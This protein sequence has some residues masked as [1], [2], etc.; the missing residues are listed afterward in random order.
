MEASVVMFE[1]A[2]SPSEYR[3]LRSLPLQM[4]L[5]YRILG[6]PIAAIVGLALVPYASTTLA[7][8]LTLWISFALCALSLDFVWGRA[9][10]FSFG[11][12]ALFGLGGYAYAVVALNLFPNTQETLTAL[13]ASGVVGALAA[14]ALGYFLFYSRL[15]DVYLSIVTLAVT[16]IIYTVLASTAGPEYHIGDAQLGGFNGIPS[17]PGMAFPDWMHIAD[18]ELSIRQLLAFA[19]VFAAAM[20]FGLSLLV[21]SSFGLQIDGLRSNELRMELLGYDVRRLKIVAFSIGGAVAGFGGGLF[22]AWGTFVNPSVFSLAQA[23]TVVVWVMIGGRGSL[24]GAFVGVFVVQ[25]VAD[26]ADLVVKQQTPLL[27]GAMLIFVVTLMPQGIV[28][29]VRKAFRFANLEDSLPLI[30]NVHATKAAAARTSRGEVSVRSIAKSFD[31]V[32]VLEDITVSFGGRPV[33][34]IIGPNGAGK[35]TFFNILTGRHH[36]DKGTVRLNGLDVSSLPPHLRCRRGLGIKMQIPCV[37]PDLSVVQNLELAALASRDAMDI[38]EVLG[39]VGLREH[40]SAVAANLSHGQ[41]QW[42]ELALVLVQNPSVILLDEPGA[43]MGDEDKRLTIALIQ[44]LSSHHT[45]IVVEHDME[46]IK[47]LD[48]PVLMLHQGKVF[49]SGSFAE[50]VNDEAVID[51]YLGSRKRAN[52]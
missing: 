50:I 3:L 24:L 33:H 37:F 23:A 34:A 31:G 19:I 7:L 28:P 25:S 26:A 10:I 43:G 4:I 12:N 11:Q 39:S 51:A 27:V 44:R 17:L 30:A 45:I 6:V 16:L 22:A 52:G 20:Y 14:A 21:R 8:K 2:K 13:L 40:R 38:T 5:K 47:S 15:S 46:F 42:L 1:A 32:H 35:S 49:K 29:F 36:P 41:Q 9:G 18:G 48:A